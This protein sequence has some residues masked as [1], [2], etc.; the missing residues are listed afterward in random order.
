[1]L[2]GSGGLLHRPQL[3]VAECK[4]FVAEQGFERVEIGVGT[5]RTLSNFFS[6]SNLSESMAKFSSLIVFR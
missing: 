4:L 1:V 6:S 2:G 5:A 3:L